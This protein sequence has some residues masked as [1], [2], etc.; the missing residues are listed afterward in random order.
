[1]DALPIIYAHH[2]PLDPGHGPLHYPC[3]QDTDHEPHFLGDQ[4]S[5]KRDYLPAEL[6]S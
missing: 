3:L 4:S 1:M 2:H 6:L 5:L